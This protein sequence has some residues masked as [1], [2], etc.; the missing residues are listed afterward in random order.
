MEKR[1]GKERG[2]ERGKMDGVEM[3]LS[4][5][6]SMNQHKGGYRLGQTWNSMFTTY[7]LVCRDSYNGSQDIVVNFNFKVVMQRKLDLN[8][9]I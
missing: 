7:H 9:A 2:K 3:R 4:L 5:Y 8:C 1:G 6:R